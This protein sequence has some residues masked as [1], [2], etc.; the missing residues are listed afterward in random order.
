M[1]C[2]PDVATTTKMY[3]LYNQG[4]SLAR[5]GKAFGVT[6]QTVYKRFKARGLELRPRRTPLPFIMFGGR[7]YTRRA[8]GYYAKTYG[9]RAYLHRAV[10]TAA[11]GPIPDGF[12]V[13][14]RNGDKTHNVLGNLDLVSRA[15]HGTRHGFAG[16]QH[17]T[18]SRHRPVRPA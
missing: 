14:H 1:G 11:R 13:H 6:R 4:Q 16:N 5:V 9:D 10:W 8:S 3:S 7:K 2:I 17:V 18:V 15:E 12:D